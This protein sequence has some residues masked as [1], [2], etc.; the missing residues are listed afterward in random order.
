[1]CFLTQRPIWSGSPISNIVPNLSQVQVCH[2]STHLAYGARVRHAGSYLMHARR[3]RVPSSYI[4]EGGLQ[5]T[6]RHQSLFGHI[7]SLSHYPETWGNLYNFSCT[8]RVIPY[9]DR[10]RCLVDP[11][12]D[13]V[14]IE[15]VSVVLFTNMG[16][17]MACP[18]NYA[19]GCKVATD[20]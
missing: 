4:R 20:K 17:K 5:K 9:S 7:P 8:V 6:P 1:M 15:N 11:M 19:I 12:F 18:R 3:F 16:E 14:Y 10:D 13:G 2:E